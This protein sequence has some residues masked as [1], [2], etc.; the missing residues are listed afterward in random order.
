MSEDSEACRAFAAR[1]REA[2]KRKRMTSERSRSGVDVGA[3]ARRA[4]VSYEMAR[5]YVEGK[6]MPRPDVLEQIAGSLDL[7]VA[8]LAFGSLPVADGIDAD[9]LAAC[10]L[11]VEQ[12]QAEASVRL[13]LEQKARIA[14]RLYEER[15]AI[16]SPSV[17]AALLRA[18]FDRE[19]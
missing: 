6:A 1:L 5:R 14:A 4:G 2:M 19:A 12:G 9:R 13:S 10:M 18:V 16:G 8:E 3:L 7:S 15:G 17:I 11:A